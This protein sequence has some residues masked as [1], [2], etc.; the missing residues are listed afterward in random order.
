[1]TYVISESR[2]SG[3]E[4]LSASLFSFLLPLSPLHSGGLIRVYCKA[5]IY[6]RGLEEDGKYCRKTLPAQ[7][8]FQYG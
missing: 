2:V 5:P 3:G 4:T 8:P 6:Q 1:M 7:G